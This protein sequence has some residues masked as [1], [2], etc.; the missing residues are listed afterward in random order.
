MGFVKMQFVEGNGARIPLIGLGT[1][2][3]RGRTCARVVENALR[4][5]YRHID[6]AEMYENEREVGEGLHASG[7]ERAQ[8]FVTTKIWPSHFEPRALERSSK[9]SLARLR[10]THV[11]LLLLHWPNPQV[12]LTDTIG[13][14]CKVKRAGLTR[15][16][17]VSNFTV[18]L[19]EEVTRLASEPLACDQI[20]L[21]P[22]I[23][24]SKVIS[25]CRSH[26]LAVVAYSPIA[27]GN[28]TDDAMLARIGRAHGKSAAQVALRYLV[29]QQIAVIPRTSRVERLSE[30]FAI[31][32]FTLSEE[33]MLEIASLSQRG[34]RI[35]DYAYLGSP[36]WD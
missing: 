36:K 3:L 23:D 14:L 11:D 34:R 25:A 19:I 22:Y 26:G 16:I 1:W 15:H 31:F 18:A 21:H 12:P 7:V 9:E 24:Q 33:E 5:G 20:E 35:V 17:G 13:A 32:D 10:L 4:L 29:Q 6:T 27:R 2:E 8:V 28:A 30:N